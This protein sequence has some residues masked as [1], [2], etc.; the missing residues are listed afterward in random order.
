MSNTTELRARSRAQLSASGITV[1]RGGR[2]VL[3]DV[4]V[5]VRPGMRL[6]IVGENGR[7]KSTLLQVLPGALAPDVGT[8]RRV[9][10]CGIAEQEITADVRRTVDQLVGIELVDARTALQALDDA[11]RALLPPADRAAA[12]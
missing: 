9:G 6:G 11:G 4:S 5:S 1:E 10:R 7:G 12:G 3:N 2:A 8:V